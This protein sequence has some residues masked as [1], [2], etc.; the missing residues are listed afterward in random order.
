MPLVTRDANTVA[1]LQQLAG[2][3]P[4]WCSVIL[5]VNSP[6]GEHRS[7]VAGFASEMTLYFPARTQEDHA[8]A[9]EDTAAQMRRQ[10]CAKHA[11][12]VV[13]LPP[14]TGPRFGTKA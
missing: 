2:C 10:H 5:A 1:R 7:Y 14:Y 3:D 13:P 8:T 11:V 9:V 6:W 4:D 12:R